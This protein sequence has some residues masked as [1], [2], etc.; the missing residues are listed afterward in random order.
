MD[1]YQ[2]TGLQSKIYQAKF[3]KALDGILDGTLDKLRSDSYKT[4]SDYVDNCY[5]EG[6]LGALYDMQ[7]QGVPLVFPPDPVQMY[8]AVTLDSK[9]S[10]PMYQKMGMDMTKLKT[11]VRE[12]LSRGIASG[13]TNDELAQN[14]DRRMGIGRYNAWRIARTE[15]GRVQSEATYHAQ[16]KAKENGADV[17]RQW[18]ACLDSRVRPDHAYLHNQTREM[19][20]P[21]EVNGHTAMHPHGFGVASEDINCRCALLTRAR[22]ALS[23]DELSQ[24]K[25]DD[26][27]TVTEVEAGSYEE[28]RDKAKGITEAQKP[29]EPTFTDLREKAG[30][31]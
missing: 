13:L 6:F 12:E 17:L 4:V 18:N 11:A 20:E 5:E 22:W 9:L 7:G 29:V 30:I 1:A 24:L 27:V 26:D 25:P 2:D 8:K 21:F 10:K 15:G 3:Q 28:F 16:Q 23:E 31:S 19:D 14:L